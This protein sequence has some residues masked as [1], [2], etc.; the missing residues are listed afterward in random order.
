MSP[1]HKTGNPMKRRRMPWSAV[2]SMAIQLGP[3]VSERRSST[4]FQRE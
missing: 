3:C 2:L 4:K 1:D